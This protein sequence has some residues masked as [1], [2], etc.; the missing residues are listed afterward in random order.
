MACQTVVAITQA[1]STARLSPFASAA[2]AR[3]AS[4]IP[5][6]PREMA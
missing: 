1:A 4:A 5:A 3:H 6:T 2:R